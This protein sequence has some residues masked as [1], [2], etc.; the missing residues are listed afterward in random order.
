MLGRRLHN[1]R[2]VRSPFRT[3]AEVVAWLGA[4]QAQDYGGARWGLGQRAKDMS[5]A[6]VEQAFDEGHILRTHVLRPT[7]HFVNPRD[8]RWMLALTAPRVRAAMAY[9]DRKLELDR[10]TF[11]RSRSVLERTLRGRQW[12]TRAEL[13]S[14]LARAGIVATGQRLGHLM[15]DAELE[16]VICSGPRRGNQFTYA[17]VEERAP[18]ARA[19]RRDEALAELARRYF[20]SHGPATLRDFTWWSGLTVRDARAGLEAVR[21][22]LRPETIGETTFFSL[23]SRAQP[24]PEGAAHLL[25]NYDEYLVAYQDRGTPVFPYA[26]SAA[27][28]KGGAF[29]HHLI[30]GGRLVGGWR[31]TGKSRDVLVEVAPYTRLGRDETRALGA[32]VDRYGQFIGKAAS[33]KV[34]PPRG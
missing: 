33:V 8:I 28:R 23:P 31:R 17:L 1:Q 15:M 13:G 12:K 2:L 30:L 14:C 18:R 6:I 32:A 24:S 20:Q 21:P 4:V 26:G 7:W 3:P 27:S 34:H 9:Y 22:A 10:A 29:V 19:L 5:D 16:G 11:A 25:P